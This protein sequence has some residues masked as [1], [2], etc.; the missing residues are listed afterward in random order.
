MDDRWDELDE[1]WLHL[2]DPA[3]RPL[4]GLTKQR[5]ANLV[6]RVQ[7]MDLVLDAYGDVLEALET[8]VEVLDG[9]G[10]GGAAALAVV[11]ERF[12]VACEVRDRIGADVRR[13]AGRGQP[14]AA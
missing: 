4:D 9:G 13:R 12:R 1:M 5:A 6:V 14:G 3:T 10:F 11:K 2:Q 7:Q 8:L